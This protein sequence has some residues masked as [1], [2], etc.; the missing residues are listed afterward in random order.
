MA[1]GVVGWLGKAF[2]ALGSSHTLDFDTNG[3]IFRPPQVA[4]VDQPG[5]RAYTDPTTPTRTDW[6]VDRAIIA[7][8]GY[9]T[10]VG[11][12]AYKTSALLGA[13][14]NAQTCVPGT[15]TATPMFFP[16]PFSGCIVGLAFWCTSVTP[17]LLGSTPTATIWPEVNAS[18]PTAVTST[19]A[20]GNFAGTLLLAT[21]SKIVKTAPYGGYLFNAGDNLTIML[22]LDKSVSA[23]DCH[24][25]LIVHH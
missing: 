6:L 4:N 14:V 18:P 15:G 5:V 16:T 1:I 20:S 7:G 9:R 12:F 11:P 2:G 13:A 3:P 19:G 21:N 24:A 8:T 22:S 10:H 23:L 25:H 17:S